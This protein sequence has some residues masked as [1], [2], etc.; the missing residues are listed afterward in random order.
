MIV[1][2]KVE[3]WGG[4]GLSRSDKMQENIRTGGGACMLEGKYCG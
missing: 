2:T 4:G 3:G 1:D